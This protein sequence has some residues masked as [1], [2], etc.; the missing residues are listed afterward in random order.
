MSGGRRSARAPALPTTHGSPQRARTCITGT[1]I[2]A[3]QL[4]SCK[5]SSTGTLAFH[6]RSTQIRAPLGGG[7]SVS[8]N[9]M[10]T[11][12]SRN[13]ID[14][15]ASVGLALSALLVVGCVRHS[16]TLDFASSR[17]VQIDETS[18]R[19]ALIVS[20]VIMHSG[21]CVANVKQDES[22]GAVTV[23]VTIEPADGKCRGDFQ[24]IVP[25]TP[26]LRVIKLGD[27]NKEGGV[28]VIW[29]RDDSA[30]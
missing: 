2:R 17:K 4:V 12:L 11:E 19:D 9:E 20:G 22:D 18:R 13:V 15:A 29:Q 23:V 16:A 27:P 1:A 5:E 28:G 26:A 25:R 30:R 24:A 21:S 3:I 10:N 14:I 7:D 8:D 6:R